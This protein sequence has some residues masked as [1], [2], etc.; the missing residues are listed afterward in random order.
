MV[1]AK[2]SHDGTPI[3]KILY[4][5]DHSELSSGNLREGC[6]ELW[7]LYNGEPRSYSFPTT[8]VFHSRTMMGYINEHL[9]K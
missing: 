3:N 4:H 2:V 8:I 1:R 5:K 6:Q 9:Y 7:F